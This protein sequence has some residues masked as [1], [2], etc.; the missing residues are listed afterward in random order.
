MLRHFITH[1]WVGVV[2]TQL[3]PAS[4]TFAAPPQKSDNT[5][6]TITTRYG[7]VVIET[8]PAETFV[9]CSGWIRFRSSHVESKF[10]AL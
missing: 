6:L 10:A 4:L 2:C 5:I 3:F 8:D 1:V 9:G 7:D